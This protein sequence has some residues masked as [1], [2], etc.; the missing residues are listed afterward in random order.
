MHKYAHDHG[1]VVNAMEVPLQEGTVIPQAGPDLLD[2]LVDAFFGRLVR[3]LGLGRIQAGT[4]E[5][6][7]VFVIG[8]GT[9]SQGL[10][11][12]VLVVQ[13]LQ[14]RDDP[15]RGRGVLDGLAQVVQHL[16]L[17]IGIGLEVRVGQHRRHR[18][19]QGGFR[20]KGDFLLI[21]GLLL[22]QDGFLAQGRLLHELVVKV[23]GDGEPDG[24]RAVG[25]SQLGQLGHIG[26]LDTE[27]GP[28]SEAHIVQRG[29]RLFRQ[30]A[31]EGLRVLGTQAFEML[32]HVRLGGCANRVAVGSDGVIDV[33]VE[34]CGD[35]F[36]CQRVSNEGIGQVV[37]DGAQIDVGQRGL[38]DGRDG[39]GNAGQIVGQ[40]LIDGDVKGAGAFAFFHQ[41]QTTV[42]LA[43]V[44]RDVVYVAQDVRL[45]QH[46]DPGSVKLALV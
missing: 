42:P 18:L 40:S 33:V 39:A 8:A 12:R 3:V 23:E 45:R 28:V 37:L 46:L 38:R 32:V 29:D 11:I 7:Q 15:V 44:H 41:P 20:R 36:L 13:V 2:G 14:R 16:L 5:G 17:D 22:A 25:Q 27:G 1:G 43:L 26:R 31:L 9:V 4:A 24:G 35:G 30:V 19:G 6:G 34:Q 10:A 21:R